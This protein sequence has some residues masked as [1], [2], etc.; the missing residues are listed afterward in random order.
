MVPPFRRVVH[1]MRR[2][3]PWRWSLRGGGAG[4]AT[5]RLWERFQA[6][7]RVRCAEP[8]LSELE[9]AAAQGTSQEPAISE[10]PAELT[11][12]VRASIERK[13]QRALMLRQARLAARPYPT[14]EVAATGGSGP[15]GACPFLFPA[16]RAVPRPVCG[17]YASGLPAPGF[18]HCTW[19]VQLRSLAWGCSP[20]LRLEVPTSARPRRSSPFL[21]SSE[22]FH[23]SQR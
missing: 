19:A 23:L 4:P 13:R 21:F 2:C 7:M 14:T 18:P 1:K 16:G 10:Q 11:A 8:R 5:T 17:V 3:A 12:S 9:M 22:S 6:P 20:P 15:D